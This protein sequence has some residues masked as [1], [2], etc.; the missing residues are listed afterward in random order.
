[1]MAEEGLL[2]TAIIV[3]AILLVL[4]VFISWYRLRTIGK[5]QEKLLA[6]QVAAATSAKTQSP[7]TPENAYKVALS[8]IQDGILIL[9][10]NHRVELVNSA[11]ERMFDLKPEKIRGATFIEVVRDYEFDAL[12]RKSVLT[13]EQQISL[14]RNRRRKQVFNV[15][16]LPVQDRTKHVVIVADMTERQRLEDIRRDLISNVS[17]EFRTPISSIKLLSETLL[18]GAMKDPKVAEDFLKKIDVETEKLEQM[19]QELSILARVEGRDATDNRGAT[20]IHQLIKHS[21][22]RMRALAVKGGITMEIRVEPELP[23]PITDRDQI[24]SVLVN[25]IHNAIKF[26]GSGGRIIVAAG[27]EE[28]SILV[29]IADTGIGISQEELTRVFERF[30]K[31]D[32]SRADEGTGLGLAISKH[33][34]SAH[35]GR[36]WVESTEGRGSTFYFT[37]PLAT[38]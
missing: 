30:Y 29:S 14:I 15:T 28:D 7:E 22:E 11:A 4:S 12:L 20:D 36:I 2:I 23:A 3:L 18:D 10:D 31:V 17:H 35:G 19:T 8:A 24:E 5:T 37:L 32:K 26:T 16:V 27:K 6:Q 38:A 9:G 34:I 1:M 33:I 21:V 13:G 25:L